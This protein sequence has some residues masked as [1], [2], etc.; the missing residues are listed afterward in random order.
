M[1]QIFYSQLIKVKWQSTY[2]FDTPKKDNLRFGEVCFD[3]PCNTDEVTMLKVSSAK[4]SASLIFA[5]SLSPYY[6]SLE[7][8]WRSVVV[9]QPK[10]L[11][12]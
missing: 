10:R 6:Q 2:N 4:M 7:R 9:V 3:K 12:L 1:Y 5:K 11:V 8:L